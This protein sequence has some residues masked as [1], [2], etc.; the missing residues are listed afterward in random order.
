MI[1][2]IKKKIDKNKKD[3]DV[4]KKYVKS[5]CE[6]TKAKEL[7]N[8]SDEFK[9]INKQFETKKEEFDD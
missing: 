7:F 8:N 1:E 4:Y 6:S 9:E 3:K 5:F 2:E